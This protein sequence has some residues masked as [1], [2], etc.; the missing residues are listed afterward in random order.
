MSEESKTLQAYLAPYSAQAAEAPRRTRPIRIVASS[1]LQREC[2]TMTAVSDIITGEDLNWHSK[3]ALK[4]MF[5]TSRTKTHT[6]RVNTQTTTRYANT[7]AVFDGDKDR[8]HEICWEVPLP[9]HRTNFWIPLQSNPEQKE[10]WHSLIDDEDDSVWAGELRLQLD[11]DRWVLHVTANSEVES[12][13]SCSCDSDS[14]TL[15][16]LTW[17]NPNSW[18]AVPSETR[19]PLTR[20]SWMVVASDTSPTETSQC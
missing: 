18:S 13:H 5:Q 6:T 3:T 17:E 14:V 19:H 12:N 16:G 8:H 4:N 15:L 2:D 11:G 20:C 7:A 1:Q 9:G 10:W